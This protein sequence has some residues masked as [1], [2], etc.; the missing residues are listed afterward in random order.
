MPWPF[1]VD[2][3]GLRN[4]EFSQ[5]EGDSNEVAKEY[6]ERLQM[7]MGNEEHIEGYLANTQGVVDAFKN[8][9][10]TCNR[11]IATAPTTK[12]G[13]EEPCSDALAKS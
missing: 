5:A 4:T 10:S 12:L 2:V 1:R 3:P 9:A 6:L 11:L 13:A 7:G 8:A